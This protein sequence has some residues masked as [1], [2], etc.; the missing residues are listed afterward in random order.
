MP[1]FKD[2]AVTIAIKNWFGSNLDELKKQTQI[3]PRETTDEEEKKEQ[4]SSNPTEHELKESTK[5]IPK[6]EEPK[7]GKVDAKASQKTVGTSKDSK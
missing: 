2:K 7:G 1:R 4:L 5:E 3:I 6:E